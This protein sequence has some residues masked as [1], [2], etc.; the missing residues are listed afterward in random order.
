[1]ENPDWGRQFGDAI[2][3]GC[4]VTR[5]KQ[6]VLLIPGPTFPGTC[7]EK[8]KN[9]SLCPATV[10]FSN[11]VRCGGQRD[12]LD[13]IAQTLRIASEGGDVRRRSK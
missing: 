13:W 9:R 5:G 8:R 3:S 7:R 12:E 4:A 10:Y 2:S 6:I 11:A 1:M